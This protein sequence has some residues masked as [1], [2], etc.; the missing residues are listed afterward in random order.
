[1]SSG[2]EGWLGGP[3]GYTERALLVILGLINIIQNPLWLSALILTLTLA[4]YTIIYTINVK[5]L[6]S[7]KSFE[8]F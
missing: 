8:V 7:H 1:L 3:I 4:I 6:F 2:I 5:G